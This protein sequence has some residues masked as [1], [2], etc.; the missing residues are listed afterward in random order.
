MS[1][2]L[3]A[4]AV[5]VV[6]LL[7]FGYVFSLNPGITEFKIIPGKAPIRTS[8][9]LILF[10]FFLTGFGVA[11]FATAFQG[12]LRSFAFWR[13]ARRSQRKD[14]A[15]QMVVEG[16]SRAA[17]GRI[18]AA[19]RLLQRAQRK[20]PGETYVALETARM[21]LADGRVDA[22]ER[23]L[24]G[25]LKGAPH[26][27]EVL[28][29]L[30]DVN[31]RRNNFEGQVATLNRWLEVDPGHLPAL[32]TLRDLYTGVGNWAEAVRVQG[33][34]LAKVTERGE[35]VAARRKLSLFRYR[36]AATLPPARAKGLL[37]QV[38]REDEVF[39]P[40]H[41]ALGD[42]LLALGDGEAALRAWAR[43]YQVSGQAG[44]LLKAEAL[45]EH[46][47]QV[48]EMLKLY[49]KLGKKGGIPL[50]LRARLLVQLGRNEEAL[51]LLEDDRQGV[52]GTRAGR[53]LAGEAQRRIGS[54]DGAA[55]AFHAALYG[56]RAELPVAFVCD[57]CHR[58]VPEWAATCAR[59]EAVDSLGLDVGAVAP[60]E[61]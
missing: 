43:G 18:G 19:R 4:V 10:L 38:V 46:D 36:Q 33:R 58:G 5:L 28:S 37:E 54:F 47:G 60:L 48:E 49:R 1:G 42:A 11:V 40:A 39:A 8:F 57:Q 16:R 14:E 51:K 20:S 44:L 52:G 31:R 61:R 12:A 2:K 7:A 34:I 6:A 17:L 55:K 3:R 53:L 41:A 59:C 50:L 26:N 27:S 22:A 23:R 32:R 25:L 56:E 35:R 45:R 24:K 29:L 13:F 30:L 21:E 9:A 15:R